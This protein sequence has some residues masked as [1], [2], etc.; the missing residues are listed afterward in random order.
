MDLERSWMVG[1][2]WKDVEAARAAGCRIIFVAGAHAD[3][4][5]CKPERVA[6]SLAEA[7]EMI[8]REMR[9]RTA[10]SG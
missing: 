10:A 6:A 2:S 1:D 3:A 8:L 9:R 7:A 5:T 4:G